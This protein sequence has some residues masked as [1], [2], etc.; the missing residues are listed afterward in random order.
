M[1]TVVRQSSAVGKLLLLTMVFLSFASAGFAQTSSARPSI[2][3]Q[4]ALVTEFD[5]GGLKV[6]V[7]RRAG[8]PTVAAGLFVRGGAR[9]ISTIKTPASKVLCS[10]SPLPAAETFP[11]TALAAR[12]GGARAAT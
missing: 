12:A 1:K 5:V 8:S 10:K 9:A 3:S 4:S 7:K 11:R 6:L 2:S